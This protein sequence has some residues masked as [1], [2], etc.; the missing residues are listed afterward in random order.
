MNNISLNQKLLFLA[1]LT[2]LIFENKILLRGYRPGLALVIFR[3]L[4]SNV[5][6]VEWNLESTFPIKA[7]SIAKIKDR[8]I[9]KACY[10]SFENYKKSF[11]PFPKPKLKIIKDEWKTDDMADA[12]LYA[13]FPQLGQ[14]RQD[15]EKQYLCTW[16]LAAE[17]SKNAP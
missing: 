13:Y 11:R 15:F 8:K 4:S 17:N 3:K 12:M 6:E 16:D 14:T 9:R 2:N 1:P 7:K 10:Q 5:P